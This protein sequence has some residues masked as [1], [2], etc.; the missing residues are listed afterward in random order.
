[1]IHGKKEN[2]NDLLREYFP[3]GTDKKKKIK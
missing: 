1:M 2:R 3:K